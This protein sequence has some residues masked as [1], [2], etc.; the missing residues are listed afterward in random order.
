MSKKTCKSL[1]SFLLAIIMVVSMIPAGAFAAPRPGNGPVVGDPLKTSYPMT[2]G[3]DYP[4]QGDQGYLQLQK[5]AKWVAHNGE[6]RDQKHYA[7]VEFNVSGTPVSGGGID[8]V[9]VLDNSGSMT[10][11][12][13]TRWAETVKAAH[14]F[15]DMMYEDTLIGKSQ[16]R[17]AVV[18]FS[19]A[20]DGPSI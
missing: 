15:I 7:E 3:P 20:W 5:S 1:L 9:L 13:S 12:G 14:A 8:A 11:Y 6:N 18:H 4:G 16:N 19:G 10:N 2:S 17:I